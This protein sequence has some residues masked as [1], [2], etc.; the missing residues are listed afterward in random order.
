MKNIT[1]I[2][3]IFSLNLTLC[4]QDNRPLDSICIN[5]K[6]QEFALNELSAENVKCDSLN[7]QDIYSRDLRI[8]VTKLDSSYFFLSSWVLK[9]DTI[10][11]PSRSGKVT[12][13]IFTGADYILG[14]KLIIQNN[15]DS[16][17]FV[18]I[19][20]RQLILVQEALDTN[21]NWTPVEYFVHSDCGNSYSVFRIP[22][23]HSYEMKI[24]QYCG[25]FKTKI[26]VRISLNHKMYFSN[27]FEGYVN[28]DQFTTSSYMMYNGNLNENLFNKE[29]Y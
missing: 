28:L 20:D 2:L 16:I 23:K 3:F 6:S 17:T 24:A 7:N 25:D 18:L 13:E 21:G 4:A 10:T 15:T 12:T 29:A 1:Q 11:A 9:P 22:P 8:I 27:E 14:N 19:E 26:R 5:I